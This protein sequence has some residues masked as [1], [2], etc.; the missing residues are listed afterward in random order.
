M[1]LRTRLYLV[2]TGVTTLEHL[3]DAPDLHQPTYVSED[4]RGLLDP[5]RLIDWR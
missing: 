2:L 5:S 3:R 1:K 4:L